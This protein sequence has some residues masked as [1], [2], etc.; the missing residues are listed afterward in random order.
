M[1]NFFRSLALVYIITTGH[2]YAVIFDSN[3]IADITPYIEQDTLVIFDLDDTVFRTA[4]ILGNDAWFNYQV[5]QSTKNGLSFDQA[6]YAILPLYLV[7]QYFSQLE[8]VDP[9]TPAFIAEL[10]NKN[11]KVMAL[12]ARSLGLCETTKYELLNLGVFFAK[13]APSATEFSLGITHKA[14][15][16]DGILF[17]ANNNKGQLLLQFLDVINYRPHTVIFIDDKHSHLE[18]I[19]R[20]TQSRGITFI[21][22]R[23]SAEDEH[24][25][26]F[27]PV[28][29]DR[30]LE[31]F[32]I[33]LAILPLKEAHKKD[34]CHDQHTITA[35]TPA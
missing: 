17:G 23:Y 3:N 21:G 13:N 10:Q 20:A 1:K 9:K 7:I 6:V 18:T 35:S 27:D 8:I 32:K 29:A 24:K 33:N 26:S 22:L 4:S 15:Y 28:E 5:Q 2:L 30:L 14:Y 16:S 25:A 19:E 31:E 34:P 11:I 12:S